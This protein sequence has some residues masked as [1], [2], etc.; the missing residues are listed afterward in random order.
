MALSDDTLAYYKFDTNNTTQPDATGNSNDLAVTG[1]TY[2]G[3]GKINGAYDFDGSNDIMLNNDSVLNDTGCAV[4]LWLNPDVTTTGYAFASSNSGNSRVYV[5]INSG[6]IYFGRGSFGSINSGVS[7]STGTWY[8][9]VLTWD[10]NSYTTYVNGVQK[11]TG[12]YTTIN[13]VSTYFGLGSFNQNGAFLSTYFN[14]KV[15]ELAILNKKVDSTDVAILY[16]SGN[17]I[18]YPFSTS[19]G[20]EGKI[21]NVTNPSKV[22]GID[23]SNIQSIIGVE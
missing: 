12:S 18:Q 14:G 17:A 20:W 6:V 11:N 8:H 1:A 13:S 7:V 16:N 21:V 2:T 23:V 10:S 9:C 15:D 22:N 3:S 19:S 4:S 5:Y